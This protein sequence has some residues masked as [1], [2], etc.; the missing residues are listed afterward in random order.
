MGRFFNFIYLKTFVHIYNIFNKLISILKT[1]K[2]CVRKQN[3]SGNIYIYAKI[4]LN[5][6]DSHT[7]IR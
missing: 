6:H 1:N 2:D 4:V 7:G 5:V 3:K